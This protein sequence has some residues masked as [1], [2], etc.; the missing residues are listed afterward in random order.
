LL[1]LF[2]GQSNRRGDS[3]VVLLFYQTRESPISYIIY[4]ALH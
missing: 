3:H 2:S 4:D 1:S